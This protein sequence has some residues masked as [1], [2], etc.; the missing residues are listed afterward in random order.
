MPALAINGVDLPVSIDSLKLS[1]EPV[2]NVQRNQRGHTVMERRRAKWM[3]DFALSPCPL[4]EAMLYRSLIL[5]DGEFWSTLT[6][7]F[8]AKGLAL[9]GTGAWIGTGGGNPI[10]T[11]G[12]W[13][14]STSQTLILPG[15]LYNQSAVTTSDAGRTGVTVVGWRRDDAAGTFRIFG[16]S[17]PYN[18]STAVVQ[19]EKLGSLGAS[20]AAQAYSGGE[21]FSG[22][23][24]GQLTITAPAA[25][26]PWSWSNILLLPWY[27]PVAQVDQLMDGF[28]LITK[29]LPQ[30]PRSF[31]TSDM[32]P[33]TQL[34]TGQA[35]LICTG[36]VDELQVTPVMRNGAYSTTEC[37]LSGS[38]TEV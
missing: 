1:F 5:G 24:S 8:G 36:K 3:F 38:L 12:V 25:G 34:S 27:L 4:Q 32:H 35:G 37:V 21:A 14:V 29:T 19:R 13:R 26:G 22:P 2:G 30:L 33:S 17:W 6:N 16:L 11:N 9:T 28:A 20:G 7:A 31:V 10:N 15:D 23:G 18:H